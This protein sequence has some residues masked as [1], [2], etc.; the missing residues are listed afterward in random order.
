MQLSQRVAQVFS[1]FIP[2]VTGVVTLCFALCFAIGCGLDGES[3][4]GLQDGD[5]LFESAEGFTPVTGT[6]V[7][8]S[9]EDGGFGFSAGCNSHG[10]SYEVQGGRLVLSGLGST[11]IGCD[12][13]RHEQ[14]NWLAAFFSSMPLI[15]VEGSRLT[16]TGDDATLVFLNREVADPDRTLEG[17]LWTIDTLISGGAASSVL[18][19]RPPTV[20]FN[21]DGSVFVDTS[22]NTSGGSYAVDGSTLTLTELGY[23]ERGCDAA[24]IESQ[25][26]AVLNDGTLT[27]AIEANRLSLDRG[28][29]GLRATT[30]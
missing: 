9:F 29:I 19:S 14:D 4:T 7:R 23:T 25:I 2:F 10:G 15:T 24:V 8:I 21:E 11:D 17:R 27:F 13:S 16:F 18:T 12:R 26:Q 3:A 1:R 22:C 5:Y 6:T 30:P 20:Q 28:D